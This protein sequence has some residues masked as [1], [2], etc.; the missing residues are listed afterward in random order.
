MWHC[1]F[2]VDVRVRIPCLA[3]ASGFEKCVQC[4]RGIVHAFHSKTFSFAKTTVLFLSF[5]I[6]PFFPIWMD[7][8][9]DPRVH[10][11]FFSILLGSLL[12]EEPKFELY[13]VLFQNG[14]HKLLCF[15]YSFQK[16]F[17]ETAVAY[18]LFTLGIWQRGRFLH[19][20]DNLK[21]WISC[22]VRK[23]WGTIAGNKFVGLQSKNFTPCEP[24]TSHPP[25]LHLQY[26]YV[27]LLFYYKLPL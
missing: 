11:T 15:I 17:R 27:I 26:N 21:S 6:P 18:W 14:A 10:C 9:A 23:R 5:P 7:L 1:I 19:S 12:G 20:G 3:F 8:P 24:A 2:S 16:D 22:L 13:I 25:S 4:T